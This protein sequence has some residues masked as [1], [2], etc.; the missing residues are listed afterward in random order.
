MGSL[1]FMQPIFKAAYHEVNG[2]AIVNLRPQ[3]TSIITTNWFTCWN[4][5]LNIGGSDALG[6]HF[7]CQS[8]DG[9]KRGHKHLA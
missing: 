7:A 2:R 6:T 5:G 8:K 9:E 4:S 1:Q 3:G